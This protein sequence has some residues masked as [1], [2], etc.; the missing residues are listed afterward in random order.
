M[1]FL[2]LLNEF[3]SSQIILLFYFLPFSPDSTCLYLLCP[4]CGPLVP[5]SPL[6][7]SRQPQGA[8]PAAEPAHGCPAGLHLCR[9]AGSQPRRRLDGPGHAVRVLQ[10][11]ARRHQV[12]HQR[13]AQ[14]GLH[15]HRCTGPPHKMPAG[16]WRFMEGS[17]TVNANPKLGS[18]M[19]KAELIGSYRTSGG[20]TYTRT[21]HLD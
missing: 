11:A 15:Q 12:L 2:T 8:V 1:F 19:F 18:T 7:S 21:T 5:V 9:A 16:G 13:H 10:P 17:Q 20:P 14:Q 6:L 4:W 3:F